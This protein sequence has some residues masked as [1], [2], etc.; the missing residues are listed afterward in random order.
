MAILPGETQVVAVLAALVVLRHG[1]PVVLHQ[2]NTLMQFGRLMTAMV[3]PFT[4]EG[5]VDL[6][7]LAPHAAR[8]MAEGADEKL[9]AD[10]VEDIAREIER[11]AG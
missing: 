9:V 5:A 7:R 3:T 4:A 1:I 10:V 8:V 2:K 11:A 6:A